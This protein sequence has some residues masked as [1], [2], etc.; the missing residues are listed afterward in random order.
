MGLS[1]RCLVGEHGANRPDIIVRQYAVGSSNTFGAD[2][3]TWT[4][5]TNSVTAT[6]AS[7]TGSGGTICVTLRLPATPGN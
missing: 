1:G 2:E 4:V 6:K 3:L 5:G 7:I